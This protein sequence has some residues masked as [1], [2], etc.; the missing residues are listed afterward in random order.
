MRNGVVSLDGP[1]TTV[2]LFAGIGGFRIATDAVGLH[3]VFANE[4]SPLACTVYRDRFGPDV[5][6]EGDIARMLIDVP[7]HDVLTAGMPCQPFSFA[8]KKKG[9]SDGRGGFFRLVHEVVREHRPKYFLIENVT[10]ML[11]MAGGRHFAAII[12]ELSGGDY[13][14]EWRVFNSAD[15]GLPQN[16]RRIFILGSRA[17]SGVPSIRS[18]VLSD[19]TDLAVVYPLREVRAHRGT[20]PEWGI[21]RSGQFVAGDLA[22]TAPITQRRVR[23]VLQRSVDPVFDFTEDTKRRILVSEPVGRTIDG[24]EIL[25]NQAGGRRMGYT[26]FGVN[27][28]APTLTATSSRHYERYL[29]G[30]RYRRLTPVEYAR[31][32]GFP[33]DHCDSVPMRERYV[34]LGNAVPPTLAEHVLRRAGITAAGSAEARDSS[35]AKLMSA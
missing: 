26:I 20:F 30:R 10:G 31:I 19:P 11:S 27:G 28:L 16:R 32:Q 35:L 12:E 23:D 24:V 29:V 22:V 14:V 17:P 1:M 6:A 34:L 2:E 3:T 18:A 5:L 25:F 33:D 7:R 13:T 4:L 8:G 21:A 15:V 9:T